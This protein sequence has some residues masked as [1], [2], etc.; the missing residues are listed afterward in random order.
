MIRLRAALTCAKIIGVVLGILKRTIECGIVMAVI[1]RDALNADRISIFLRRGN[2][3]F[4]QRSN[5]IATREKSAMISVISCESTT[6]LT[7]QHAW[8]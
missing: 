4:F 6:E 2:L 7:I 3:M 1:R 8:N 5:G